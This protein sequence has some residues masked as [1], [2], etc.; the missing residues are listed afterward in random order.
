M[1]DSLPAGP[2][3][4]WGWGSVC[5][6]EHSSYLFSGFFMNTPGGCVEFWYTQY[7]AWY[8]KGIGYIPLRED[9]SIV[10]EENTALKFN[11]ENVI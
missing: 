11:F 6:S 2:A 3:P 5:R 1:L 8:P 9:K 4:S 7:T 10:K